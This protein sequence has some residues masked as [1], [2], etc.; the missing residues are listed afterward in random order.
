ML[1]ATTPNRLYQLCER[2]SKRGS[3]G[4]LI[5]GGCLPTGEVPFKPF[6]PVISKIKRELG[7]EVIVHT[8]IIDHET[9]RG[10]KEA[11]VDAALINVVGSDETIHEIYGLPT[12]KVTDFLDSLEALKNAGLPTIPH[13]VVGLHYG[14]LLGEFKAIDLVS[15]YKPEALVIVALN[16]IPGTPMENT[17]PPSPTDIA[18]VL[19]YARRAMPKTPQVL[20]CARPLGLHKVETDRLAIQAGINAIAFPSEEAIQLAET[21]GLRI[22]F[23]DRCCSLIYKDLPQASAE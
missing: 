10:L 3:K 2:L 11:N 20:G 14:R 5:S 18:R 17:D 12:K 13:I 16:P 1:P 4:C 15:R 19:I 21:L 8:N 6:L 23:S 22:S 7:L 9:A